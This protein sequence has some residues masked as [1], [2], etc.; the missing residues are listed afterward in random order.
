MRTVGDDEH[1]D[2]SAA[3]SISARSRRPRSSAASAPCPSEYTRT[4]ARA[5][6]S[7]WPRTQPVDQRAQRQVRRVRRRRRATARRARRRRSPRTCPPGRVRPPRR[8]VPTPTAI[9]RGGS[10]AAAVNTASRRSASSGGGRS[11]QLG[12]HDR[13]RRDDRDGA[14]HATKLTVASRGLLGGR[15]GR[16]AAGQRGRRDDHRD[17]RRRRGSNQPA[18]PGRSAS[19]STTTPSTDPTT[20]SATVIVGSD[21]VSEPA[22]KDDCWNAVPAMA[23]S[24][25]TYSSGVRS[26]RPQIRRRAGRTTPL[27]STANTPHNAPDTNASSTALGRA[28]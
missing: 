27:V 17:H 6:G 9:H 18:S 26:M 10:D 21:A 1:A 15:R 8:R 20:G 11:R 12:N 22:R 24:A 2:G 28:A 16:L 13:C 23:T 5:C 19:P 4:S 25:H 7:T 3:S 14:Q